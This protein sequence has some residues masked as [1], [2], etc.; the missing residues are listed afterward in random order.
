GDRVQP[1]A[2]ARLRARGALLDGRVAAADADAG[3]AAAARP[4]GT[5]AEPAGRG[6]AA[7]VRPGARRDRAARPGVGAG[8][9]A[10]ARAARDH[11]ADF[12]ERLPA[13]GAAGP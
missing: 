2:G 5:P 3:R 12:G 7:D 9:R 4:E 13:P 11:P 10:R 6:D 1:P 8:R